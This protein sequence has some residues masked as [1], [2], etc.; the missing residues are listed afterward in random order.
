MFA[1]KSG[2]VS[3]LLKTSSGAFFSFEKCVCGLRT[4]Q[5]KIKS[6]C[7]PVPS[8]IAWA[9]AVQSINLWWLLWS[10]LLPYTRA[11]WFRIQGNLCK[12]HRWC[13]PSIA[14]VL[15]Q[16]NEFLVKMLSYCRQIK[17]KVSLKYHTADCSD[18]W[19]KPEVLAFDSSRMVKSLN[20]E[21]K[22]RKTL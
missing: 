4:Y 7:S 14:V 11:D 22:K 16:R 19:G 1:G 21:L 2:I 6:L 20:L 10:L 15:C 13:F 8:A 5:L 17:C 18:V 9:F 3:F 12:Y